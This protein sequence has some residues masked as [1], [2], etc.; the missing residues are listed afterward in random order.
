MA[1]TLS[2]MN[3]STWLIWRLTSLVPS[4]TC[5]STSSYWL[6]DLLGRLGDRAHPAVVGCRGREADDDLVAGVVV[7]SPRRPATCRPRA[8]RRPPPELLLVQAARAR[9]ATAGDQAGR[10]ACLSCMG[11]DSSWSCCSLVQRDGAGGGRRTAEVASGCCVGCDDAEPLLE[12]DGDDDDGSLD[13]LLLREGAVVEREDVGERLEDQH[14]ED[15]ADDGAAPAGQQGAADDD[16]G[17]RVELVAASR[18]SSCRSWCGR[19]ASRPRCRSRPRR[20]R[21]ASRCAT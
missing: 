19:R 1:S 11:W 17:D 15:G 18:A 12:Q 21:R 10:R 20:G 5:S 13:E 7:A 3:V 8:S 16:R 2:L 4:A 6:G 9:T 14:A